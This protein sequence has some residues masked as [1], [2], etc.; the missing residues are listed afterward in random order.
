M[1]AVKIR[2]KPLTAEQA[3][4]KMALHDAG[5][6]DVNRARAAL[7]LLEQID[8]YH[9]TF[10]HDA[11]SAADLEDW[12]RGIAKDAIAESLAAAEKKIAESVKPA[13][14]GKAVA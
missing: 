8:G 2:S 12:V 6:L 14:T 5:F 11:M 10:S 13:G 4:R 3:A 7:W 9:L 1:S